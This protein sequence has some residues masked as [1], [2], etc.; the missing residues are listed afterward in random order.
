MSKNSKIVTIP[1]LEKD[2]KIVKYSEIST[3]K[4]I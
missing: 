1:L 2:L 4:P 3:P